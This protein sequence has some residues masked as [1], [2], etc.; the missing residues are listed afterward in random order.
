MILAGLND[1][2]GKLGNYVVTTNNGVLS[3][4]NALL[5]VSANSTNKTY[6]QALVF[7]GTEFSVGGLVSTDFVSGASLS[8][9]G[10]GAGAAAGSYGISVSNAVGDAG[11]TNYLISYAGGT[12]T[13]GA[14][15][16]VTI[17]SIVLTNPNQ[18][19][20]T[21]TG[22]AGVVYT[23]QASSDLINWQTI[24][25][26]TATNG[27]FIFIDPN[28]ASFSKRFYRATL[29]VTPPGKITITS[30]GLTNVN[31][32]LIIATGS[33][34]VIYTIQASPD[35]ITWQTIGTATA[36]TNGMFNFQDPNI[37][38]FSRRF[39]RIKL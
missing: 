21:G 39:Y 36:G 17:T 38:S 26:A 18:A 27:V 29:A 3:V 20:I 13:V 24:G 4:T 14:P 5:T 22:T 2:N 10:A 34:D 23:I 30:I 8:S 31:H 12:L 28:I 1:P 7:A 15:G 37:A 25:T 35:L 16:V 19:K 9:A 33:V 11:L 32:S 6:G